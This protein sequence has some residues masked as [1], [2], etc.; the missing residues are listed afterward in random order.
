MNEFSDRI[1]EL[2]ARSITGSVTCDES[3]EIEQWLSRDPSHRE[4]YARLFDEEHIARQYR[5]WSRTRRTSIGWEQMEMRMA[6]S[7]RRKRR[8]EIVRRAASYFS[9]AALVIGA[10]FIF[11]AVEQRSSVSTSEITIQNIMPGKNTA[12]IELETGEIVPLD[13]TQA[14]AHKDRSPVGRM[15]GDSVVDYKSVRAKANT[16]IIAKHTLRVPEGATTKQIVLD[17]GTSVWLNAGSALTYPVHFA[18]GERIV[19]MTGEGF[20]EVHSDTSRPFIVETQ[21]IR[22]VVSGTTFNLTSYPDNSTIATTL[23]EGV[24]SVISSNKQVILNPSVQAIFNKE[25]GDI[26]MHDVDTTIYTA[27]KEGIFNFKNMSLRDICHVLSRWYDVEF[28]L[29]EP[30]VGNIRFTGTIGRNKSLAFILDLI[31]G[32]ETID[33]AIDDGVV[34]IKDI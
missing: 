12:V 10:F 7:L 29:S 20:F 16:S 27:W 25:S 26:T 14:K 30:G 22:V 4:M 31:R 17:D 3:D 33:Y 13:D 28:R 1:V 6:R 21:N 5:I 24:V 34:V 18:E 9:A 8:M 32:T 23:V 19:Q 15:I 11:K 2:L